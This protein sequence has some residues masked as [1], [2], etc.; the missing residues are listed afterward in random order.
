MSTTDSSHT[1]HPAEFD[2]HLKTELLMLG[3]QIDETLPRGIK[4][5]HRVR[6]GSCGGLDLILPSGITV[7]AP[8]HEFFAKT[9]PFHLIPTP[10][11]E[12]ILIDQRTGERLEVQTAIA[13]KYY[14]KT[15]CSSG[16]PMVRV[17]Q[18]CSDRLG[19]GLTNRCH[20][21]GHRSERCRFCS[22][23]L[24]VQSGDEVR[25]KVTEEILEV[26]TAAVTDPL[27][28]AR[29]ILLGGGTPPGPDAG[30]KRIA[31]A[32]EQ[33]KLHH[34]GLPIYA[35]IAPPSDRRWI[36][37]LRDAGV[38]ELGMN[39]E[40]FSEDAA[41]RYIPG[42][43]TRIGLSG[44]LTAL[45]TSVDLFGPINTRSIVLAGLEPP[46]A[47]IAGVQQLAQ[48]GVMPILTPFRPLVGTP[49]EHDERWSVDQMWELAVAA[50]DAVE[51]TGIPMGPTCIPC[52]SNT[53]T[54]HT[55]DLHRYY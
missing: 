8:V 24:N 36:R 55:H 6:S 44:Y 9:S 47:T 34:P 41:A 39:V 37:R 33:V 28:P 12:A 13:P 42:K 19:I 3:L 18:V 31:E 49:M 27:L 14:D 40:V 25:D 50:T 54:V 2:H 20:F 43:H 17:G 45:A 38:D 52:Q 7:N 16:T 32:A 11:Q 26:T 5:P 48:M 30:A 4:T 15:I 51:A 35:M 29:H 1:N 53:L 23:G 22:I 21:W 10:K 46:E